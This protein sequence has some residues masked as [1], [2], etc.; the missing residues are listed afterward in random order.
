MSKRISNWLE[1]RWVT[2]AYAGWLIASLA[3]FFFLAATNTLAGWLYVISGVSFA[4]LTVAAVSP[5]RSLRGISVTR[6]PV[7]PVSVA[8]RLVIELAIANQTSRPKT[9]LQVQDLLATELGPPV[10]EVLENIPAHQVYSW[11]HTQVAE[12]RGVFRWQTVQLRT[13]APLGLFWCRRSWKAAAITIVYPTVLPLTHCPLI[14][15]TGRELS[16]QI[17]SNHARSQVATAG[18]T[19]TLR[20]YRWGDPTRLVH[21]RSSARY[22][23]LRVRE[24]EVLTEGPE[25]LI[26]LDNATTWQSDDFEQAVI[27]AASLYFYAHRHNWSVQLWTAGTGSVQGHQPVLEALAQVGPGEVD[28]THPPQ[29]PLL[30]LSQSPTSL[31]SLPSG[32]RWLLWPNRQTQGTQEGLINRNHPGLVIQ[33]EQPLQLQLQSALS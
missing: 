33:S 6:K 19:R 26:C 3:I 8:D 1:S 7:P 9:L 16:A 10:S 14:D 27:A 15:E 30:W 13:A 18:L 23:E 25:L 5:A 21:W 28:C 24:L 29:Q 11:T 2:P 12:R 20:P 22:G 32:S 17:Q 31:S 4:L